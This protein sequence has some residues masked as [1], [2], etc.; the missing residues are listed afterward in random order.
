[1]LLAAL[2]IFLA[3]KLVRRGVR[4]YRSETA[5]Q[6]A[7][8]ADGPA[9]TSDG[10]GGSAQVTLVS[11]FRVDCISSMEASIRHVLLRMQA[12]PCQALQRS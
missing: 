1:M 3:T 2:L 7:A 8:A 10:D 5:E 12:Q 9:A 6:K 4:T 11:A